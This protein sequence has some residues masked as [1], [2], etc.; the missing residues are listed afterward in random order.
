MQYIY[1]IA[2]KYEERCTIIEK[3]TGWSFDEIEKR[4]LSGWTLCPP[5]PQPSLEE[6]MDDKKLE[7]SCRTCTYYNEESLYC[8]NAE[9]YSEP[10]GC[11]GDW[12]LR[13]EEPK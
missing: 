7:R 12:A 2:R 1:E 4:F 11:C 13:E 8:E 9:V 3:I 10:W 5:K 6:L